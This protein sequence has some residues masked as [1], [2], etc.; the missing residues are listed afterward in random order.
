[1]VHKDGHELFSAPSLGGLLF[2]S[3]FFACSSTYF[4]SLDTSQ[5]ATFELAS[6]AYISWYSDGLRVVDFS[7]PAAPREIASFVPPDLPDPVGFFPAKALVWGVYVQGDLI[8]IS[9]TNGGLY[10]LKH[11][12]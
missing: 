6:T 10:V 12:P 5:A 8:L 1:M 9:D 7:S 3:E 4:S 11:A 2:G